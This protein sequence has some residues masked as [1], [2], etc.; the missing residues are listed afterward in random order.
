MEDTISYSKTQ[1]GRV[2]LN[3]M[4]YKYVENRQSSKHVFWRC[5]RYVKYKCRATLVTTKDQSMFGL[6]NY[7]NFLRLY[8]F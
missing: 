5:S 6:F 4:G 3:Y 7:S 1:R 8:F 2:M